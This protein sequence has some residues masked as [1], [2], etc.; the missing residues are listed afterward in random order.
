MRPG[1]NFKNVHLIAAK[2]ILKGLRQ[3]GLI[4]GDLDA[5]MKANLAGK[6]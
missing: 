5:M 2:E 3:G 6:V 4:K 1:V